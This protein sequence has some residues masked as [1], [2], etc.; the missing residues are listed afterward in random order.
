MFLVSSGYM[1]LKG[2][3]ASARKITR[4]KKT[5]DALAIFFQNKPV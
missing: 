3:F 5:G 2:I 1:S 4:L